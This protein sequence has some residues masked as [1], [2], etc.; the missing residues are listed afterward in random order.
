M[1]ETTFKI[2]FLILL[3]LANL[4]RIYYSSGHKQK[5][6]IS[7]KRKKEIAKVILFY[8]SF[9]IPSIMYIFTNWID[10]FS[11]K[12]PSV[13]RLIGIIIIMSGMILFTWTHKTLKENFSPILEIKKNHELIETGPY[14]RIRHPMYTSLYLLIVGFFLLSLNWI[15]GIIPLLGF[16]FLYLTRVKNEE[17]MM[18]KAFGEKYK[19]YMKRTGRLLPRL[20]IQ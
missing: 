16:S 19:E 18:L 7:I 10:L 17:K 8:I 14:K 4:I 5:H 15:V 12:L 1:T 2:I 9:I 6:S 3:I 13:F 11:F 20:M